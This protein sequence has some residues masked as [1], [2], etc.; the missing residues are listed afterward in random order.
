MLILLI[1]A[2][3]IPSLI[4]MIWFHKRDA[5]PEPQAVLW[6]TA[7]L[8]VLAAIPVVAVVLF[9]NNRIE[10]IE[11]PLWYGL[12]SAFFSAAIPEEFFKFIVLYF[13]AARLRDFDEPMDG[14]VYGVAASLGFATIENILYV[15]QSGF[16]VAILRAFTSVP[17][18]ALFGAVMGVFVG[19][20]RF[21]GERSRFF[22]FQALAWPT[23]L[24]GLYDFPLMANSA[25]ADRQFDG[26]VSGYLMLLV[27]AVIFGS[28]T[29]VRR[30]VK[31]LH[32]AQMT[33]KNTG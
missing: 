19:K 16:G 11:S 15:T 6:K 5:N 32:S 26:G 18:H 20:A 8:G 12:M 4:L 23:I 21:P 25:A 29:W 3:V 28:S 31:K 1:L 13:Y 2:A 24:H 22:L 7:G 14:V 27:P 33:L 17:A 9:Y 30:K 10:A